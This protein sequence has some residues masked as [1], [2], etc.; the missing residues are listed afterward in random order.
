MD[1]KQ[2]I[3]ILMTHGKDQL[4][5]MFSPINIAR[6][7]VAIDVDVKMIFSGLSGELLTKKVA[8]SVSIKPEDPLLSDLFKQLRKEGIK[9]YICSPVLEILNLKQEDFI[10]DIDGFVG[11]MFLI[12]E[13]LEADVTYSF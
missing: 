9:I 13:S 10:E 1:S 6:I 5:S 11:G 3:V 2:K 12:T 7:A 4:D 8:S